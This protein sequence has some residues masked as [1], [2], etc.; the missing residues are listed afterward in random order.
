M[1]SALYD[2]GREGFLDGSIDTRCPQCGEPPCPPHGAYCSQRCRKRFVAGYP[3]QERMC[4][5]CDGMIPVAALANRKYC[6]K[7]CRL[8]DKQLK[9]RYGIGIK[10]YRRLLHQQMG[11]CAICTG[12]PDNK[13][14]LVDHDHSTGDVRGLLCRPCNSGI[15][16]LGDD[17]ARLRSAVSYLERTVA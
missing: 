14:L 4:L 10:V 5:A 15:G 16:M 1:A 13:G 2:K 3:H 17:L 8:D 12:L 7:R 6:S 9:S 11:R